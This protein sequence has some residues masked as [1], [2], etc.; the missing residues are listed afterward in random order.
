MK[1]LTFVNELSFSRQ[2]L[3]FSVNSSYRDT[4]QGEW[5][6]QGDRKHAKPRESDNT[7]LRL[8]NIWILS[9]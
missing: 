7:D 8:G 1:F 5:L 4:K 3:S 9:F 2:L 6:L